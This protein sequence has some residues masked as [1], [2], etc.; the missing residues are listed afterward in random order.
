MSRTFSL[1]QQAQIVSLLD[2]ATDAAGRT[3]GYVS[4]K[5]ADHVLRLVLPEQQ[6]ASLRPGDPFTV[7]I[8][9][10]K[11]HVFRAHDGLAMQ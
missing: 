5:N 9:P 8:D 4:L 1:P 3:S 11:I 6:A 2:P 10:A 7:A